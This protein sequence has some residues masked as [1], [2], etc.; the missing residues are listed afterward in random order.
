MV[1]VTGLAPQ[2][3]AKARLI[4]ASAPANRCCLRLD[5][6][7]VVPIRSLQGTRRSQ[8]VAVALVTQTLLPWLDLSTANTLK[9]G[10]RSALIGDDPKDHGH[11]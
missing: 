6:L 1:S 5:R 11:L 7:R 8:G 10:E 9:G 3:T 4:V 2:P